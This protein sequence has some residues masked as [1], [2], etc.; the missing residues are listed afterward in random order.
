MNYWFCYYHL[1]IGHH[2]NYHHVIIKANRDEIADITFNDYMYIVKEVT[3]IHLSEKDAEMKYFKN[4]IMDGESLLKR[5]RLIK[6][7]LKH[8]SI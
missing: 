4:L 1:Y 6:S 5:M 7:K 2:I 8:E 3:E